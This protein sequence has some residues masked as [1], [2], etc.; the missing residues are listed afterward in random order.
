MLDEMF[1]LNR[2]LSC[3]RLDLFT[4]SLLTTTIRQPIEGPLSLSGVQWPPPERL[5]ALRPRKSA[6]AVFG[7]ADLLCGLMQADPLIQTVMAPLG[8]FSVD[9]GFASRAGRKAAETRAHPSCL[10][11][12]CPNSVANAVV[13]HL[14][15]RTRPSVRL[16]CARRLLRGMDDSRREN[17]LD[18]NAVR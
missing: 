5:T 7:R 18:P 1:P 3:Q 11:S 16:R 10:A 8:S 2:Q 15:D 9:A 4:A 13:T 12:L 17:V 6:R 14:H